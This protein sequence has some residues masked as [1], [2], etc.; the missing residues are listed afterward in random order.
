MEQT[1]GQNYL[2]CTRP[3]FRYYRE[4]G[5]KA[6]AQ[7]E[8]NQI[9]TLPS[10]E[11]NSVAIIVKHMSGNMLSRFSDFLTSD[12][13]KPWRDRESEFENDY[14]DKTELLAAWDK[15]WEC[16]FAAVDPLVEADL[17]KIVYIRNQGH[18]V[19]EALQRQLAHYAYHVGQLVFVCRML[20]GADWQSLSI[21]KGGSQVFNQEKF[22]QEKKRKFFAGEK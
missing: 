11:S 10:P 1:P 2:D 13:E 14:A 4:L 15:G 8:D 18:S 19:L 17:S 7:I 5:D 20:A 3:L 9:H 21:P 6:L 16:F 22:A 12:G